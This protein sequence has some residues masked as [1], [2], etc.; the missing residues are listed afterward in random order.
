MLF[1][2]IYAW[3]FLYTPKIILFQFSL[4]RI[5][6]NL[7]AMLEYITR[8]ATTPSIK[9]TIQFRLLD[10]VTTR[11]RCQGHP[12][13]ARREEYEHCRCVSYNAFLIILNYFT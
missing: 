8:C 3:I 4:F 1:L 9:T 7:V 6:S 12:L 11:D 10:H 13:N 5:V 2:V